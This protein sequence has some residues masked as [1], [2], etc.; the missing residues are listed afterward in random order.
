LP[1]EKIM[2]KTAVLMSG[3]VDSSVAALLLR[4]R[5]YE[6]LGLTIEIDQSNCPVERAQ[7]M[8]RILGLEHHAL[9]LSDFFQEAVI[10]PFLEAYRAGRTPNPCFRCN[11]RLKFGKCFE[12]A[13]EMGAEWIATGH[14]A[15]ILPTDR[16]MRIAKGLDSS[17]DQSYFLA[18]VPAA[19]LEN[20]LFPNGELTKEQVREIAR[21]HNLPVA[22]SE[23]SQ[24]ICFTPGGNVHAFLQGR[25]EGR[26]GNI[27]DC[28]GT[29]LGCHRG[30]VHYTVGQRKG[31][32]LAGGPYYVRALDAEKNQVLVGRHEELLARRVYAIEANFYAPVTEGTC[33]QAKIRSRH[34]AASCTVIRATGE[35]YA[36]EF[37][38]PQWGIAPGQALVLYDG[39][40]IL[41]GGIIDRWD[42]A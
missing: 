1:V 12:I 14:Y 7:S 26:A 41:A 21:E 11:P 42:L 24:E 10:E 34:A 36:V 40:I 13:R 32:G 33:G 5:G 17:K 37:T 8:A 16:G 19:M 2:R 6:V 3:G 35:T 29:V 4:D 22:D 15:R 38:E 31:L 28:S 27:V 9:A 20:I 25:L 18:G 30:I 23:E 39:D